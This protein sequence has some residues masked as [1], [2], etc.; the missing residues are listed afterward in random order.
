M[1]HFVWFWLEEFVKK[2]SFFYNLIDLKFLKAL[3]IFFN[4]FIYIFKNFWL[5]WVFIAVR[6]LSL[7]VA[8]GGYTSLWCVG[9]SLRWLLLLRS[10]GSRCVGFQQLWL[11]GSR[12]QAQQLWYTDLVAP[13]PVGSSR[14][15]ARTHVPCTG[16][17]ILNRC[18]SREVH[19]A[20]LFLNF[21]FYLKSER[22][23]S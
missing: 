15:R 16:R 7:V 12:A 3:F 23:F 20:L 11:M 22:L 13:R 6:R 17:W 5:R 21:R 4:T 19:K 1:Q 14:T 2:Y 9:F 10:T 8:R 18:A